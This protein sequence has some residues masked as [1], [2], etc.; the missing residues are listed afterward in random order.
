MSMCAATCCSQE[1]CAQLTDR[2]RGDKVAEV[3]GG[4]LQGLDMNLFHRVSR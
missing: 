2:G 3:G 1:G 4:M